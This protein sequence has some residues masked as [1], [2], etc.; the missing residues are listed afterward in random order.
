[1]NKETLPL[2]CIAII[3]INVANIF[4]TN[5][6]SETAKYSLLSILF[7]FQS[8]FF[9]LFISVY[10]VLFLYYDNSFLIKGG[11]S[12]VYVVLFNTISMILYLFV[13]CQIKQHNIVNNKNVNSN[14]NS[15]DNDNKNVSESDSISTI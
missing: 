12:F 3:I 10:S 1:M 14:D 9:G 5:I 4:L 11:L 2:Y 13:S 15:N 7:A 6:V 8:V